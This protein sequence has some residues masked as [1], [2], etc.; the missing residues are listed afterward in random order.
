MKD[1]PKYTHS[2]LPAHTAQLQRS[3]SEQEDEVEM[4]SSSD[5]DDEMSLEES[6]QAAGVLDTSHAEKRAPW[7]PQG[8]FGK[9][10]VP[11]GRFGKR[12]VPQGRFGKRWVPQGRFGKRSERGTVSFVLRYLPPWP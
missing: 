8:R 9:R 5:T 3:P 12:W 7:T 10:W 2:L 4:L 6:L 1:F 11:Q